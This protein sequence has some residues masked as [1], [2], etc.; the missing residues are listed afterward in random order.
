MR[1][2]PKKRS[3]TTKRIA[4]IY[5]C[6][7]SHFSSIQRCVPKNYKNKW[8][9]CSRSQSIGE[10]PP[11]GCVMTEST[12]EN[13]SSSGASTALTSGTSKRWLYRRKGIESVLP[14]GRVI[15]MWGM[16]VK[17]AGKD[18]RGAVTTGGV[19]WTVN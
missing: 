16:P 1:Q 17:R 10:I 19:S 13:I 9:P 7:F 15:A 8:R 2:A 6:I 18:I 4:H 14:R 5:C 11:A 12:V 3:S